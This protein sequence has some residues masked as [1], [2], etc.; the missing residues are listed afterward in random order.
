MTQA[1]FDYNSEYFTSEIFD[2]NYQAIA[3]TIVKTYQPKRVAEFGCGP[4]HLTRELAR[5]GVEV[6][7]VDGYS[8][9]D[10]SESSIEF[11]K[12]DLNDEVA[13]ANRFSNHN[14]DLAISLE[15]AEHL[16]PETSPILIS[17]MTS[18]APIVVFSAAV[19]SQSGHGHINL[20]SRDYWHRLF[21]KHNFVVADRIR[22][23]LRQIPNV[24]PWYRYNIIDYLQAE[25]SQAPEILEVIERLLASESA[26]ST[27][28]YEESTKMRLLQ[29]YLKD[30]VVKWYFGLR[31]FTDSFFNKT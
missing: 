15:V 26:A 29:P 31:Q 12:L 17:W 30:P 16:E 21:T 20:H 6:T 10:F 13:I 9:P 25:H 8:E 19:P 1:A 14:F 23:K 28:Y 24:A 7:A 4:G 3:S 27:A 22:E 2:T 5:L 11:H 18:V